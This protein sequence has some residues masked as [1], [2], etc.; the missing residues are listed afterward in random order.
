MQPLHSIYKVEDI[1]N[2]CSAGYLQGKINTV[3]QIIHFAEFFLMAVKD[4]YEIKK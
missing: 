2:N 3:N 4:L 1:N